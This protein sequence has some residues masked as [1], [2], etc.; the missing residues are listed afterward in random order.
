MD[1]EFLIVSST[2]SLFAGVV[3]SSLSFI[4]L[5]FPFLGL[6]L[7]FPLVSIVFRLIRGCLQVDS[8]QDVVGKDVTSGGI[9]DSN[10]VFSNK[11]DHEI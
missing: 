1:N 10:E 9:I 3:S 5:F 6:L 8:L 7:V 2:V 11:I 4:N